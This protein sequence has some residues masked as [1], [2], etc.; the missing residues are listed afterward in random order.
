MSPNPR[1]IDERIERIEQECAGLGRAAAMPFEVWTADDDL[2]PATE[3]RLQVAVQAAI[4]VAAHV[5]S[6]Q[7]WPTPESYGEL[8]VELGRQAVIDP[9][10][11]ARLRLAAGL[12]NLLVH[13][14]RGID[15]RRLHAE[16]GADVEDLRAFAGAILRFLHR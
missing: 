15:R 13:D 2:A 5:V 10:L 12:R 7:G 9:G 1:R 16:L 14:Y 11:A 4:D 8:F 6:A 3:H